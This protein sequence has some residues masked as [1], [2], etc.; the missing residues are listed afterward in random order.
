M[1]VSYIQSQG[2]DTLEV[3]SRLKGVRETIA[4]DQQLLTHYMQSAKQL[5]NVNEYQWAVSSTMARYGDSL[6][7]DDVYQVSESLASEINRLKEQLRSAHQVKQGIKAAQFALFHA[8]LAAGKVDVIK[9]ELSLMTGKSDSDGRDFATLLIRVS[10]SSAGIVSSLRMKGYLNLTD[11]IDAQLEM[12]S[13]GIAAF[14]SGS[15]AVAY[16]KL[17][18]VD[19]TIIQSMVSSFFSAED[20][21]IV[22]LMCSVG[23]GALSDQHPTVV[24]DTSDNSE[25]VNELIALNQ[26]L[27]ACDF[28]TCWSKFMTLL[29]FASQIIPIVYRKREALISSLRRHCI[30]VLVS[31]CRNLSLEDVA[32]LF[33]ETTHSVEPEIGSLILS[34]ILSSHRIDMVQGVVVKKDVDALQ[35]ARL[36]IRRAET[37]AFWYQY[38]QIVH[39]SKKQDAEAS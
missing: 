20:Y 3:L 13:S 14:E 10:L 27:H 25:I 32:K 11:P 16:K 4:A 29:T 9:S 22:L 18:A 15:F 34:G 17:H 7:E 31:S 26:Q 19:F 23:S 36:K 28:A 2:Y 5:R 37:E 35:E 21:S 39:A 30:Y 6:V 8:A 12:F 24:E 38:S 33:D 1:S